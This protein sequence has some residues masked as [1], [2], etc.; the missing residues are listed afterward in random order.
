MRS[1]PHRVVCLL[2]LDDGAFPRARAARRRRPAARR[3][4]R[5]RPRPAQ[6][7]P[8]AAARRAAGRDRPAG[9]HL[10]RQRRAHQRRRGRPPCRSASCST[11]ST[12]T[13][14]AGAQAR[15]V[16]VAPPAAAVRPAQLHARRARARARRGASTARRSRARAALAGAAQRAG[17]VPRRA[18]ARPRR[19]AVVELDDLVRFVEHPVRG[20][21]APAARDPRQRALPTRSTTR[22]RSSS[23]RSSSGA[24][25]SGCSTPGSPAPSRA[26]RSLAEI[27]RGTLPPGLLGQAGRRRRACRRRGDR[28]RAPD[29]GRRAGA[30]VDVRVALRGGRALGGTVAG[31]ARRLLRSATLRARRP[32]APAGRL[33][34]AARPD[35]GRPRA[36]VRGRHGRPRARRRDGA[37]RDDR[38]HPAARRPAT[39]ARAL[40][41]LAAAG[42][43]VRPRHAR[44]AAALLPHVGGLRGRGGEADRPDAARGESEFALRQGGPRA[45]APARARRRA[46]LRRAAARA[47]AADEHG[48]GLGRRRGRRA[49]AATPAGCGTACS[50]TRRSRTGE[51]APRLRRLRAAA[52][53]ASPCSRRAPAR[54]RRT[55]SPRSPPATS[56]R[57]RRSTTLL[58]V[59]FTRMA[60]GELRERVRERLV[61]AEQALAGARRRAAGRRR[62]RRGCSPPARTTRCGRAATAS[63]ARSP[64]STRPRSP[65]RTASASEV[66]GGLGVAG[67]VERDVHVR[68]GRRTTSSRRSSTTSTCAASTAATSRRF[69]RARG[70]ADRARSPS[71]TRRRR[72]SRAARDAARRAGDAPAARR[73]GARGARARASGAPRV[74]TYDDLL[75]RLAATLRGPGGAGG[76][77]AAARA[78]PRRARRRVP[79]HRP[80]QWDIMRRAFG[81]GGGTLV[82]IGDPKQAIYAFRGADVYAYLDG[83][84]DGRRPRATLRRQLA[85]RPGADRRLRR[86]V[87]RRAARPRG[88]RLPHAC[89]RRTPTGRRGCRARRSTRRCASGSSHRDDPA[90]HAARRSGF[91]RTA[92]GARARRRRPRRRPRRA[93][94]LG[95]A[96]R[97]RADD[98]AIGARAR[99]ARPRRR[100]RAH[101]PQRGAGP[102]RARRGRR[103]RGHQRRRQRVRHRAGA[104]LAAAARGARAADLLPARARRGAHAVPRLDAPSGSRAPA[105]RRGRRSTGACTTGRACC[106]RA[107]SP[108]LLETITLAEGLPRAGAARGPT[109]SASSPTCATSASCC[110]R[111]RRPSSS[112]S[113]ALTA[114]AAAADRRGRAGHGRRGAQPPARVRRRGRAG[115]HDP[116]QQGARVPDRLLPVPVGARLRRPRGRAGRLPRPGRGRRAHDRRR[117]WRAPTSTATARSTLVEQRGEDLRLAYV[118][119]TRAQH[120]AVVWWAG[121]F[122]SR[123]SALG[124]LLFARDAEGN[125]AA[126]GA[127]TPTDADAVARFEALA[128]AAPGCI[129]SSGPRSACRRR[130]RARPRAPARARGRALRPRAR[131]RAGGAPPT[132]TSPPARTRRVV[133][134]EPEEAGRRPT[135]R[136]P[137]APPVGR[138]RRGDRRRRCGDDPA[139]R[140]PGCRSACTSARS[141][142]ACSRRP[143]SPRRTSTPSSRRTSRAAQARGARRHRRSRG[144]RAPGCARRSRRRSGRCSAASGCATSRRADRLDELDF[145][146][147]LAG[148]DAPTGRLALDAIADAAASATCRR[149]PARRLRRAARA[150][151]RC[152]RTCAATS[153]AASTSSSARGERASRSST[154]RRTGS[155]PPGEAL[156]AWHHRPAALRAEMERAHYGLQALLYTVA[157]HRYLRWRLPGLR[158]GRHL[159]GVLYLFVRGMTGRGDAGRGRH[160]VRRVRVAA[161]AGARRGAE[162]RARPRGGGVIE[163]ALD[164]RRARTRPACCAR[165]T[166]PACSPRPTCTSRAGSPRSAARA[167]SAVVLAAALAVRGPRLGHVYVDLAT[168]RDTA[169]VDADEPVDLAALPWPDP[170]GLGRARWPAARSRRS[171]RRTAADAPAAPRRHAPLPRPLLARGAPGR[172]RPARARRGRAARRSRLDVARRRARRA[173][174]PGRRDARRSGSRAGGGGAA[175]ASP[176]SP[177][178]RAP[179]RR[180]PWRGSSRCSPSRPRPTGRPPPLV[181]LAAPTGKAAARLAEAVHDEARDARRRPRRCAR[182]CSRLQASTLHR[183]LGWRPDSHSRF[184]HH[185][186]NPLPHDVVVV[187]E[188]SMVSLSLMARLVEAVRPEARLILV[189]DPGQLTS[190][191]AGAV[192]GDI[193][194]PA[195][196]GPRMRPAARARLARATGARRSP[197]THR[198]AAAVGDG[199]VVLEPRAPLRRAASPRS[200]TAVRGGDADAAIAV[201]GRGARRASR[202]SRST[203]PTPATLRAPARSAR[204]RGRPWPRYGRGAPRAP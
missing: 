82:L 173:S 130:G 121:S 56:P 186:A 163:D 196:D 21:P 81:D 140:W 119:L 189:G 193:V 58:L 37:R 74:I 180:R 145:E 202:G 152:G 168:I 182:C 48:A 95:G 105:R 103:P 190:I 143:T 148:G 89:A 59:T 27:A 64:T 68:R 18:A 174:S 99:P 93:A 7:G 13:A 138:R 11:R 12:A 197:P 129:A 154:T 160:A 2:G 23:T 125:V 14:G 72:S 101:P 15:Q 200:P 51:R 170:T 57:G 85:Q 116:P 63:P 166:T 183:L 3:P 123:D 84:A 124:R 78:L 61:A 43:P 109:A 102:R 53:P 40:Q 83:G 131:P 77:R 175:P 191:E 118:A 156:T 34:A 142:T 1:V 80:V 106:A 171:G 46:P 132:A 69:D 50:R 25:A 177:A 30:R 96:D 133:A 204:R 134:S 62:G 135:S 167:T 111:R 41:H 36:A 91:A 47:A 155:P 194:G 179:A 139:R 110:T 144:G 113:T 120:Q 38:P 44:A 86:A 33:G 31:V 136:P 199:I 8:P 141:C 117:R 165:S 73:R 104:R 42:R 192:L 185:R 49:S 65:R 6:R 32:A 90:V 35:R 39:G 52:R 126:A 87:R 29:A 97:A 70:A 198:P 147:P 107:A 149:R 20:V 151:R 94:L 187:D 201:L 45:R 4:A 100:A 161:A 137:G 60:T 172:R 19:P 79:G 181:A 76:R 55:R 26:P 164:V 127:S 67:D 150:T 146:L 159:A 98:G 157:L 122:D 28:R 184:R 108:S 188:T 178:G 71:P 195:A 10:H 169:T 92:A 203:P 115:A 17:A 5:R 153:P 66:L 112:A 114:L 158:P 9:R 16:V 162:R 88:D 176:S 24:S 128:A 22:C 75:T 54:A